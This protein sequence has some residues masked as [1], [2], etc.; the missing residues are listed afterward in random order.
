MFVFHKI[1]G[2]FHRFLIINI[3]QGINRSD[4]HIITTIINT[5]ATSP[6]YVKI[7]KETSFSIQTMAPTIVSPYP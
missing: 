2:Y 3:L 6:T 7:N 4:L 1:V 5:T